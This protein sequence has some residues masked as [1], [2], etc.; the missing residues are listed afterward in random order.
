MST[1]GIKLRGKCFT[2][3]KQTGRV[4]DITHWAY[5]EIKLARAH[6]GSGPVS[7]Y[8]RSTFGVRFSLRAFTSTWMQQN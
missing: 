4:T 7:F 1:L 5:I 6:K 2:I 3:A 8:N